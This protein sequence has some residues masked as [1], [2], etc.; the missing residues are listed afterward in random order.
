MVHELESTCNKVF[1][2]WS[3]TSSKLSKNIQ[4]FHWISHFTQTIIVYISNEFR[5]SHGRDCGTFI[6]IFKHTFE[7]LLLYL[8][9]YKETAIPKP[10]ICSKPS[11]CLP[12]ENYYGQWFHDIRLRPKSKNQSI[13]QS[14]AHAPN[15]R[16]PLMRCD[17]GP[18]ERWTWWQA[19]RMWLVTAVCNIR[20]THSWVPAV[21]PPWS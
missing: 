1:P 20:C 21:H 14:L 2:L 6:H 3:R 5:I 12:K 11:I 15:D 17:C 18:T 19:S 8:Y 13:N 10:P 9:F 7:R 16:E 4:W